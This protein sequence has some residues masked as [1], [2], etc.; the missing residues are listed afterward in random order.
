MHLCCL[1]LK[2]L[3][4]VQVLPAGA[5]ELLW[6]WWWC[7]T[8]GPTLVQSKSGVTIILNWGRLVVLHSAGRNTGQVDKVHLR[9]VPPD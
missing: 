6:F 7:Y 5:V 3:I 2:T 9:P 8:A 1:A 4:L